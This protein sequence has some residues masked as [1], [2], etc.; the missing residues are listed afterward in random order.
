MLR[1]LCLTDLGGELSSS[2]LRQLT[3]P[4]E[5]LFPDMEAA[6]R[7]MSEATDWDEAESSGRVVPR[8]V[9]GRTWAAIGKKGGGA[10]A[11]AQVESLRARL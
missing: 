5:G 8:Q 2:L 1:F 4:G 3:T 7:D 11:G 6:L 9:R 10:G